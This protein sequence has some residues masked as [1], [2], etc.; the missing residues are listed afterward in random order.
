[1][2]CILNNVTTVCQPAPLRHCVLNDT[3]TAHPTNCPPF[4]WPAPAHHYVLDDTTITHLPAPACPPAL[5]CLLAPVHCHVLDDTTIA[6]PPVPTH[7]PCTSLCPHDTTI[8]N[9]LTTH[10]P[11]NA[12]LVMERPLAYSQSPCVGNIK[13]DCQEGNWGPCPKA[14]PFHPPEEKGT[15]KVASKRPVKKIKFTNSGWWKDV[16]LSGERMLQSEDLQ[17]VQQD[18]VKFKLS[19]PKGNLSF[20]IPLTSKVG[21]AQVNMLNDFLQAYFPNKAYSFSKL[22]FN[23]ATQDTQATYQK[24]ATSLATSLSSYPRV[25]LFLTTHSDEDR[26]DLFAGYDEDSNPHASQVFQ[27]LQLL[28]TPLAESIEGA[29]MVFYVCGSV[30]TEAQSFNG[31][32]QAAKL[33]KPRSILLFDAPRLQTPTTAPYLQSLLDENVIK[34]FHVRNALLDCAKLGRHSNI[35]L[36]VWQEE[37]LEVEKYIWTD[38]HLRPW[39]HHLPVACPQ[40][41][42]MQKWHW[43]S[44]GEFISYE[45]C[46]ADYGKGKGPDGSSLPAKTFTFSIPENSIHLTQGKRGTSS[47]LQVK[48]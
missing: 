27:V 28:L 24:A 44:A 12:F 19:T 39:G 4:L 23:L 5:A 2:S 14:Q 10:I 3:T 21:Q 47:W 48:M 7:C 20:P 26:G 33:F 1:M 6:H 43:G 22:P 40:C 42:T 41:A 29:D 36:I 46:Y 32:K 25:V 18:H 17:K 11:S 45:C 8:A 30:V 15:A 37:K 9:P 31:V 38:K 35:I 34:G 13:I 16:D